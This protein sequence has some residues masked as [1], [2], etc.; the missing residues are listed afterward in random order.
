M[1]VHIAGTD[2]LAVIGGYLYKLARLKTRDFAL[3]LVREGP[4]VTAPYP[5]VLFFLQS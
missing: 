5:P 2:Y 1:R 3:E 4:G